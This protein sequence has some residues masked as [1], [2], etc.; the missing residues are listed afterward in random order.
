MGIKGLN[1]LIV[2]YA[3][4]AISREDISKFKGCKIAIDSEILIHKFRTVDSKNSHIF[5]F[6]N[7]IFWHLENGIIPV[8]VFDGMPTKAKI[9]N[10]LTKRFSIKEQ[11]YK[12]V[13]ELE[14]KFVEQ[15][16]NMSNSE[17]FKHLGDDVNDTLDELFKIQ[18]KIAF[19][20]V[21]KNHRNECKYLLKLMGIPFLVANDDAEALCV[22]LQYKG[23][24]DYIYTEDTDVI[25]Y[26]VG[27]L[28]K[29][30]EDKTL[31]DIEKP[32]FKILKKD[33]QSSNSFIVIDVDVI[34]KSME[35]DH[36]SFIDLCILSGCDFC[37]PI[38]KIGPLK[39]YTY[40]KNHNLID[41]IPVIIPEYFNYKEAR[42]IFLKDHSQIIN[43]NIALEPVKSEDLKTYLFQERSLNPIPII[44]KYKEIINIFNNVNYNHCIIAA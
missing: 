34:L 23:I 21:T 16:D 44:N 3:P 10:I 28:C 6:I 13:E 42:D 31:K 32:K 11:L 25:P 27:V 37:A 30:I 15:I 36:R 19:N 8:Y 35:L 29:H 41:K 22:D 4:S 40:I 1:K 24:V 38:S 17:E 33:D 26:A 20:T 39:A 2:Q 5:G 9:D 18:R 7:N 43:K 14:N 12:K